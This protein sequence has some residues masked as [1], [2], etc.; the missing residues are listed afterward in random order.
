MENAKNDKHETK[1]VIQFDDDVF[2]NTL[3]LSSKNVVGIQNM[4]YKKYN[5]KWSMYS[6][7]KHINHLEAK[8]IQHKVWCCWKVRK[9]L[10]GV[11]IV[12]VW[13]QQKN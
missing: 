1:N 11:S 12:G 8:T 10:F 5:N 6:K 2:E 9:L 4:I 7:V 3:R 13:E